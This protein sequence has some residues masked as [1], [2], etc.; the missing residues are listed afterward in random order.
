M[1]VFFLFHLGIPLRSSATPL[2]VI[3]W[4]KPGNKIVC[5]FLEKNSF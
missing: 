2:G 4:K 5:K 3:P 1:S